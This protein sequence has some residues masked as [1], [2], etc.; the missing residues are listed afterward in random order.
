MKPLSHRILIQDTHPRESLIRDSITFVPLRRLN[1]G[2]APP[3]TLLVNC[4]E[5][6]R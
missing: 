4:P 6:S 2:D 5:P 1:N 3:C